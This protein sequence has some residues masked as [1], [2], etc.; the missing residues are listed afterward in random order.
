M[1]DN[2]IR[3]LSLLFHLFNNKT[4]ANKS[5]IF[6]TITRHGGRWNHPL[7]SHSF[8]IL[9][10]PRHSA[11][12]ILLWFIDSKRNLFQFLGIEHEPRNINHHRSWDNFEK[13]QS[14]SSPSDFIVVYDMTHFFFFTSNGASIAPQQQVHP[15]IRNFSLIRCIYI[16]LWIHRK[17][18]EAKFISKHGKILK[19]FLLFIR[20]E[21]FSAS[22]TFLS[23][24]HTV[25][26][27]AEWDE[28]MRAKDFGQR[29][30]HINYFRIY[31][32]CLKM[33][34]NFYPLI[35]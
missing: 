2:H 1:E 26:L 9:F 17:F 33:S 24:S 4:G 7:I 3:R 19:H 35:I 8:L 22:R 23:P 15:R 18:P 5:A 29:V 27:E 13:N 12:F 28:N 31:F 20:L 25:E 21:S 6:Q 14:G 34:L 16:F 10:F 32:F 30:G 11:S